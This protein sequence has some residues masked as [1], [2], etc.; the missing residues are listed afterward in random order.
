[1]K[2]DGYIPTFDVIIVGAGLVGTICAHLLAAK[3]LSVAVFEQKKLTTFDYNSAIHT[4]VSS[5]NLTSIDV[6][7]QLD[8]WSNLTIERICAFQR[9]QVFETY[10]SGEISFDAIDIGEQELGFIIEND[11]LLSVL[12]EKLKALDN[13]SLFSESTAKYIA[14][15]DSCVEL[16]CVNE[17]Q[18]VAQK[19][20]ARLLIGADGQQSWVRHHL[21]IAMS[22]KNYQQL[23]I[24]AH[25]QTERPHNNTARQWFSPTGPLAF[26]PLPDPNM[27]SIVWSVTHAEATVLMQQD[28]NEFIKKLEYASLQ[29]CGAIV[30]QSDRHAF[31]LLKQ[32]TEHYIRER[33]A[34]IGD[35]AH[36]I[37][38]LAGQGL[39]LGILDAIE[40]AA[41]I[42]DARNKQRD[43]GQ[44]YILRRFERK[45]RPY[46]ECVSAVMDGFHWLFSSKQ[47]A[48]V[49]L[50]SL[51]LRVCDQS[52]L[53]FFF[54]RR[55]NGAYFNH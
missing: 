35:A 24:V 32:S 53:K 37:H 17:Q 7:N 6:L 1:M 43:F 31:P 47:L 28:V 55:A 18:D 49:L 40:L 27:C 10:G 9:M 2:D 34:L 22:S 3:G 45:S 15:Q 36:S 51:G 29:H 21:R 52:F 12:I 16:A 26:L 33:I 19:I 4:R 5:L 11:H 25:I 46:N 54:M 38:P 8:I 39:N 42:H 13:V 23:A 14:Q 48:R 50:R 20:Q 30:L 41:V 44:T